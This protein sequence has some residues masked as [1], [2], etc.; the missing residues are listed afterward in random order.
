MGRSSGAPA[1][2]GSS[3][4]WPR[5]GCCVSRSRSVA[6]ESGPSQTCSRRLT[7][8]P[9]GQDGE[10]SALADLFRSC[11][12]DDVFGLSEPTQRPNSGLPPRYPPEASPT[13]PW[14]GSASPTSDDSLSSC[15]TGWKV[16]PC[17]G[18]DLLPRR[19]AALFLPC[20]ESDVAGGPSS[21]RTVCRMLPI[22][23]HL[24]IYTD[25]ALWVASCRH[26]PAG[27]SI[28]ARGRSDPGF[29]EE[30]RWRRPLSTRHSSSP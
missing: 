28:P 19:R 18:R 9:N 17:R 12:S 6:S 13:W 25:A 21:R 5:T 8:S 26:Q 20:R 24:R 15:Q 2:T 10:R 27:P 29:P 14:R 1:C 23:R 4:A 30:H 3:T 22:G 16:H 7:G 11:Q